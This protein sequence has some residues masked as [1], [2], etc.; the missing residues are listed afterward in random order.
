VEYR[1]TTVFNGGH[2]E[3][4]KMAVL[5]AKNLRPNKEGL[6]SNLAFATDIIIIG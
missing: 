2:F 1:K 6:G 4:S 5:H 3:K